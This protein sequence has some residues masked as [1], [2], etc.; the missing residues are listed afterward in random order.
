MNYEALGRY[1]DSI[2][3]L[4]KLEL[5]RNRLLAEIT[6]SLRAIYTRQTGFTL[7][8]T[9]D[10]H[11]LENLFTDIK[12]LTMMIEELAAEA[13]IHAENCGKPKIT[14]KKITFGG[15]R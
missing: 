5:Q 1:T 2:E 10:F 3:K 11:R 15:N 7:F 4:Q 9:I 6:D 13:N 8:H 12:Q 14:I